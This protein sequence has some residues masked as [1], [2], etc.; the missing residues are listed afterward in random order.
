MTHR[1]LLLF[2]WLMVFIPPV[3]VAVSHSFWLVVFTRPHS[4]G[5]D[6]SLL[7]FFVD[8]LPETLLV[9]LLLTFV[10]LALA[11]F[12]AETLFRV[13]RR[14]Q[15]E[16]LA[17]EQDILTMN[18]VMQERERLSRKL[19]DGVAQLVADLLLR[20][21]TIK[22]LVEA[23]R[24]QEAE[25]E[26]ERLHG[27]A[28]EI[29]KDIEES[30]TGL[31]A[32]VTDLGLVRALQDYVDL[33]EERHQIPV[34]LQVIT[35]QAADGADQ[36]RSEPF[37][38]AQDRLVE[39]ISH[40]AALQLFRLIQ[41]ALTNIR[42]HAAAREA[43]VTLT[44]DGSGQLKVVIADDGQGFTPGSPRNGK[45]RRVGLMSMRERVEALGGTFE[46]NSRP[47]SGTQVTATIP[48][49]RT[50][51]ERGHAALATSAG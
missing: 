46:V 3:I 32:N 33:F 5:V 26:L 18:A 15:A 36:P 7:G 9:T 23:D 28:D 48:I 10:A 4:A 45:G 39:S 17:R 22:E 24:Q 42:K 37:G 47:G 19:H 38:S 34:S 35:E 25:A 21:D 14:L 16:A 49:P 50:R 27:V 41:E 30:I 31:R 43:T 8:G 51:R 13:L 20:M 44:S 1:R 2:K 6:H 29:Y 12:F 40:L 11:Y